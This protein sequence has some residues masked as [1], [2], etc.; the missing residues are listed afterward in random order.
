MTD[1]ILLL[2][3]TGDVVF[4]DLTLSDAWLLHALVATLRPLDECPQVV[5][6]DEFVAAF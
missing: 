2:L 6:I 4:S 3:V 5:I 1:N